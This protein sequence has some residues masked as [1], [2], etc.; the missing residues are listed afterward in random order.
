M[1]DAPSH[2]WLS[3]Y[4]SLRKKAEDAKNEMKAYY[5]LVASLTKLQKYG[6]ETFKEVIDAHQALVEDWSRVKMSDGWASHSEAFFSKSN[7]IDLDI[8][9]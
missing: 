9:A 8:L 3:S 7:L 5:I 1:D 4:Q 2:R 6:K